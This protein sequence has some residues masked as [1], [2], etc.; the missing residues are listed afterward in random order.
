MLQSKKCTH[1]SIKKCNNKSLSFCC[2]HHQTLFINT[3]LNINKLINSSKS[4]LKIKSAR[5]KSVKNATDTVNNII[6]ILTSL[7]QNAETE[8][9]KDKY[10]V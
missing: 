8:Q 3:V 7:K 1:I 10:Y 4:I 9:D 2:S 5:A 6:D